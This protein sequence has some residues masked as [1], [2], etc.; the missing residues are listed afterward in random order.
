MKYILLLI[1]SLSASA[2][3]AQKPVFKTLADPKQHAGCFIEK[4][5]KVIGNLSEE[6]GALFNFGGT[7]VLF[8]AIKKTKGYTEAFGNKTYKI[9][10]NDKFIKKG[11][12][13]LEDHRY[14]VKVIY[15]GKSY[16]YSFKGF[17]GC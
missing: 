4:G 17:C 12:G 8:K 14:R 6:D 16:T 3:F 11:D 15:R 10:V 1:V 7:D 9:Y 13:C 5:D 2:V